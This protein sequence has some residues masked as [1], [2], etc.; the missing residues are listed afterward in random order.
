MEFFCLIIAVRHFLRSF[1]PNTSQRKS[2]Y[3]YKCSSCSFI[4]SCITSHVFVEG[5]FNQR[6]RTPAKQ[7]YAQKKKNEN[8]IFNTPKN[9][10][11]SY[12]I[13]SYHITVSSLKCVAHMKVFCM[14]WLI[15]FLAAWIRSRNVT[16]HFRVDTKIGPYLLRFL[17]SFSWLKF[18]S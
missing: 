10:I 7:V 2:N 12:S 11:V 16:S 17:C 4:D 6:F 14:A 3:E 18:C 8:R 9:K 13:P 1:P 15:I 5:L